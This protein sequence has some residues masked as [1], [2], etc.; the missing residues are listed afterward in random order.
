MILDIYEFEERL[1]DALHFYHLDTHDGIGGVPP[2]VKWR[3]SAK[4]H[5]IE[6]C[7][8][9]DYIDRAA[10]E[11]RMA[12][13]TRQGIKLDGIVYHDPQ[14]VTRLMSNLAPQDPLHSKRRTSIRA[15][16]KIK[17]NPADLT[18]IH[19]WDSVDEDYAALPARH[20]RF[21]TNLTKSQYLAIKTLAALAD[22]PFNTE[23]ECAE[24]RTRLIRKLEADNPDRMKSIEKKMQRLLLV[25]QRGLPPGNTLQIA[26]A[27]AR[28][29]GMA[30][31]EDDDGVAYV[32]IDP[33]RRANG[34]M[35]AKNARRG[36]VKAT[37]KAMRTRRKSRALIDA[38]A[39]EVEAT[40][41]AFEL[42]PPPELRT[43]IPRMA[44]AE[45]SY[46]GDETP[47]RAQG[48]SRREAL[49]A[50]MKQ[51]GWGEG[52]AGMAQENEDGR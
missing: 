36:G 51:S 4:L 25:D 26:T 29:D 42:L 14:V 39:A 38:E 41:A 37:E 45:D 34:G 27:H 49:K 24:A 16:V 17:R 12:S 35:P 6:V 2:I 47:R 50:K 33:P 5:S 13:L 9:P 44:R 46:D 1:M 8:D 40:K 18:K 11:F 23:L 28:H 20:A 10:G 52:S 7:R 32:P 48:G 3:A 43:V 21:L 31:V 15:R 19:V 22:M 30:P